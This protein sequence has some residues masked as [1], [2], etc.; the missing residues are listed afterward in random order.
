MGSDGECGV[1]CAK[2][3]ADVGSTVRIK[4]RGRPERW[5]HGGGSISGQTGSPARAG[6]SSAGEN[7]L[8]TAPHNGRPQP[9]NRDRMGKILPQA[10]F[11][12]GEFAIGPSESL[13]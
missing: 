5:A 9:A 10:Q 7:S 3:K 8:R 4:E 6:C 11:D 2:R 13:C 1:R 12:V